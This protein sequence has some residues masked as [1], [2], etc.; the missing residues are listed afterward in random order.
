MT[1]TDFRMDSQKPPD[2]LIALR[3]L[4]RIRND[5]HELYGISQHRSTQVLNVCTRVELISYVETIL[6]RYSLVMYMAH[7][8][9]SLLLMP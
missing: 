7:V 8:Q 4:R 3:R 9:I 5:I 1:E 2:I 6:Y